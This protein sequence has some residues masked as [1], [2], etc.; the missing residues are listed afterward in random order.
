MQTILKL[1]A[2]YGVPTNSN[3]LISLVYPPFIDDYVFSVVKL[4]S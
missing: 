3:S 1:Q 2:I 4:I